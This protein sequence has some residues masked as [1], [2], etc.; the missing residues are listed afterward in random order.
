MSQW[1]AEMFTSR[2]SSRIASLIDDC[3]F[4]IHPSIFSCLPDPNIPKPEVVTGEALPAA[5]EEEKKKQ[6]RGLCDIPIESQ[7]LGTGQCRG[8][9]VQLLARRDW[10]L[11]SMSTTYQM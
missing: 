3:V 6:K 2:N 8:P 4:I 11:S 9:G 1:H 5:E 10:V 7:R